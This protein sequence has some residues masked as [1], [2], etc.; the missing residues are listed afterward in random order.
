[1]RLA[2]FLTAPTHRIHC[3]EAVT[4]ILFL[5]AISG[6]DATLSLAASLP[7]TLTHLLLQQCLIE[8]PDS[9]QLQ[10]GLMLYDSILNSAWFV[11]TSII[12]FLN[13][14]RASPARLTAYADA[15]A[16]GRHFQGAYPCLF[17]SCA[18]SRDRKSVV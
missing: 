3:F 11:R 14:V 9:N 7:T 4:A 17:R 8:D 15:V 5:V 16:P 2:L 6:Y 18:V 12:L 1:M 13:K 10:E